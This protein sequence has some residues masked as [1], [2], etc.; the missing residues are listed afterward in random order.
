MRDSN[1]EQNGAGTRLFFL[2]ALAETFPNRDAVLARIAVLRASLTFPKET[3][4]VISDIHGE[5]EKLKHVINN[6]SG[7]LRPLVDRVFKG[8]LSEQESNELLSFIYYPRESWAA[9]ADELATAEARRALVERIVPR[10]MQILRELAHRYDA[11]TLQRILPSS[12]ATLFSE[13][14]AAG[15]AGR[16]NAFVTSILGEFCAHGGEIELLRWTARTIRNLLVSELVVAGDFGDRGPR[17]DAVIDYVMHQPNV[18]ITWGNHDASWMGACLGHAACI[19][20][21]VRMSVRYGRTAQLEQGYGIPLAPLE[22]LACAAYA[23]DPAE[24]FGCFGSGL[25][26]EPLLRRMQKAIAILQFKVEAQTIRRNADYRLAGRDLLPRVDIRAG[27]VELVGR[28]YPLRDQHFP[29]ID[30]HD[31]ATLSA[32]EQRCLTHLTES[33]LHSPILWQQMSYLAERG[34]MY[35]RRDRTLI[36]HGCLPVDS[37]GDFQRFPVLGRRV[38]GRELFE[39]LDAAVHR[40]FRDKDAACVDLLWYLWAGPL[41]PVFGKDKLATFENYLIADE[42]A[43]AETKNPYFHL[44]NDRNFCRRILREFGVDP[45]CGLIVNGHVPVKIEKGESPLKASGQAVTIDGAFSEIYGDRGYTLVLE[46][47][48]S[49]LAQHHHFASV[50]DAINHGTDIIPT[51]EVI[52]TFDPPRLVGDSEHGDEIREEIAA[53][54]ELLGAFDENH[55]AEIGPAI[56]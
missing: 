38:A 22:E 52:Q 5:A 56:R 35:L 31:P 51:V 9:R 3:I 7:S 53:L 28:S 48:R 21:V 50:A 49:F 54:T 17:I 12:Y 18:A 16:S 43:R 14:I 36:F 44:I 4:H 47:D 19:A 26:D 13:C 37:T 20:T 33:F 25:A 46:A 15:Q 1:A 2:R 24:F 11:A 42:G 23:D 30:W 34:R 39:A 27:T 55:I 6:G 40:A 41:S 8:E 10:E 29:T 32:D 45:E